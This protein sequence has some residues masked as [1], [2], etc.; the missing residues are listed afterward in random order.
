ME[1]GS[2]NTITFGLANN[3]VTV[4]LRNR[5]DAYSSR[6]DMRL[7]VIVRD[8]VV[9]RRFDLP[10]NSSKFDV[11]TQLHLAAAQHGELDKDVEIQIHVK[12]WKD[13]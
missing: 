1:N 6:A 12:D 3:V 7:E 8:H 11:M 2:R 4:E 10:V 5:V 9:Q 13:E